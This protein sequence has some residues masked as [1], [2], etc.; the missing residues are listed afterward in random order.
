MSSS[1][2]SKTLLLEPTQAGIEKASKLLENDELVA[3]PTETVFGLGASAIS[4]GAVKKIFKVKERPSY[5]PLIVHISDPQHIF[6]WA[7]V[8]V[9]AQ[10][11]IDCFY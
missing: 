5:N 9:L 3:F 11:L 6:L 10:K 2:N 4:N 1:R 7:N 8:P